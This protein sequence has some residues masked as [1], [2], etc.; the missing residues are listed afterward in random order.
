[1]FS[2]KTEMLKKETQ[3]IVGSLADPHFVYFSDKN[4][5]HEENQTQV[6]IMPLLSI[7]SCYNILSVHTLNYSYLCNSVFFR[8]I[9]DLNRGKV[10]VRSIWEAFMY[11]SIIAIGQY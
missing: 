5:N 1:M 8:N 3:I 6:A 2:L 4:N 11:L 7:D 10:S 9:R